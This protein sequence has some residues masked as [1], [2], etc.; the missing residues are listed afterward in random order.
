[1]QTSP[2]ISISA[3]L[4]VRARLQAIMAEGAPPSFTAI[5]ARLVGLCPS[6]ATT[7]CKMFLSALLSPPDGLD[8]ETPLKP[9]PCFRIAH[10]RAL[11]HLRRPE[12]LRRRRN[13]F[14]AAVSRSRTT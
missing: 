11:D 6:M 2:V 7:S 3:R 10:N 9:W 5:C 1:V 12:P 13:R 8:A 4:T 14:E